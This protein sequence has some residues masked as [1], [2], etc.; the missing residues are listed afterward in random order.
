MISSL[1]MRK[2]RR[3][4]RKKLTATEQVTSTAWTDSDRYFVSCGNKSFFVAPGR[5]SLTDPS[6]YDFAVFGLAAISMSNNIEI[7]FD[8]PVSESIAAQLELLRRAF[9]TWTNTKIAPLRLN[10]ANVL[11]DPSSCRREGKGICLSGGV[12]STAAALIAKKDHGFTHGMLIAGADY[13]DAQ[14]KGF[15][16]LR[17]RISKQTELLGFDLLVTETNIRTLNYE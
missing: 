13:P 2:K 1:T 12:D 11:S 4:Y 10:L 5:T 8:A 14:T 7:T 9:D 6:V 17:D 3:A 16:E 15:L